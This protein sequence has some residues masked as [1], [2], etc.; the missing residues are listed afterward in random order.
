M[1]ETAGL[2]MMALPKPEPALYKRSEPEHFRAA[3]L[4]GGCD[5]AVEFDGSVSQV[6]GDPIRLGAWHAASLASSTFANW[7]GK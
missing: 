5:A 1:G 4:G 7:P 2:D 6:I 3:S